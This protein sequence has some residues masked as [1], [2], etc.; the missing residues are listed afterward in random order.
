MNTLNKDHNPLE[1]DEIENN[2]QVDE[3]IENKINNESSSAV[4]SIYSFT[5]SITNPSYVLGYN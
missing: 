3:S 5:D 4:E 2:N 1:Q